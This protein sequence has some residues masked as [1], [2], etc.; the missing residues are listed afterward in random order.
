[1]KERKE[2]LSV[3]ATQSPNPSL[4]PDQYIELDIP[5]SK[6]SL[7]TRVVKKTLDPKV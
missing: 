1:L 3:V 7:K 6:R 2:N 5:G 4:L